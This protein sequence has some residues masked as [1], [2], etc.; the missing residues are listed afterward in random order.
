MT[1][2]NHF[3]QS[4]WH[5]TAAAP[6]APRAPLPGDRVF[7]V[8]IVGAGYTGLWTAYYLLRRRP[9][10]RIAILEREV[11][12]FGASG[13]NGGWCSSIFPASWR[14]VAREGGRGVRLVL[15][16]DEIVWHDLILGRVAQRPAHQCGDLLLRDP[17]GNW[18]YQFAV[19]V[20]DLE[21]GVDLVVRG[22]D[23]FA[24]TGRQIML[25]GLLG[26]QVSPAF[27]HHRLI[28]DEFGAKL[29]KRD[30]APAL[31]ALRAAGQSPEA[32]LGL[33]A[34]LTGLQETPAPIGAGELGRLFA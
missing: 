24:S 32:A 8:A 20:D 23:L 10:L 34:Q 33:A 25:A 19:V 14:R 28:R 6:L 5:E 18:T 2:T 12:G 7:D 26:R 13:R 9:S 3:P 17:H 16:D 29:S 4:L 31:A 1:V 27:L 30:G 15:P 21:H 11:A 22:D